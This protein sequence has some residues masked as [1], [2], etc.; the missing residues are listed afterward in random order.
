MDRSRLLKNELEEKHVTVLK[1][2]AVSRFS[3]A[4]AG[5]IQPSENTSISETDDDNEKLD[6]S[7]P[8]SLNAEEAGADKIKSKIA[9]ANINQH[10]ILIENYLAEDNFTQAQ[11]EISALLEQHPIESFTEQELTRLK[12]MKQQI[13]G[14]DQ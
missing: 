9:T 8:L 13:P 3:A 5:I 10:L 11:S 12:K 7:N 14:I 4:G 6:L 2:K 1:S